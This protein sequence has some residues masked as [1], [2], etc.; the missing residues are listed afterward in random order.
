MKFKT[1][2]SIIC[3]I[4]LFVCANNAP[5]S[6]IKIDV[7]ILSNAPSLTPVI[8]GHFNRAFRE[9]A[10]VEVVQ[11]VPNFTIHVVHVKRD[12]KLH[13]LAITVMSPLS[14]RDVN[15]ELPKFMRESILQSAGR[16]EDI[17]VE[18]ATESTLEATVKSL[19]SDINETTLSAF[20]DKQ[21][22]PNHLT[23]EEEASFRRHWDSG[24]IT[25]DNFD[26]YYER[27]MNT[28]RGFK[29]NRI[30]YA[31]KSDFRTRIARRIEAVRRRK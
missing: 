18:T 21:T 19:V 17:L 7:S 28:P 22:M 4:V 26:I 29:G 14:E 15:P 27:I 31:L 25:S 2:S 5:A 10:D 12:E 20:K 6:K 16:L 9:L 11:K 8:E 24:V 30:E 1:L 23:A 3:L 13:Q